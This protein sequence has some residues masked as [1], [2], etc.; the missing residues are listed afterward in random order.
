L[1]TLA[2]GAGQPVH[3]MY[4]TPQFWQVDGQPATGWT[5]NWARNLIESAPQPKHG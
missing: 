2:G 3:A 5:L 1:E 4:A